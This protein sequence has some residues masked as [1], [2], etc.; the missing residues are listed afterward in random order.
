MS[1]Q[2]GKIKNKLKAV[3]AELRQFEEYVDSYLKEISFQV[4]TVKETLFAVVDHL[5]IDAQVTEIIK[6]RR[7]EAEKEKARL[8]AELEAKRQEREA[9]AAKVHE[10]MG[11][12]GMPNAN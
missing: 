10:A 9:E 2:V 12:D 11:S 8:A 5:G 7:E 4:F 1:E 3:F 6:R